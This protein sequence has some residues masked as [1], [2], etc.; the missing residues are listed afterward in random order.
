MLIS[1][2]KLTEAKTGSFTVRVGNAG[3]ISHLGDFVAYRKRR[4]LVIL[5]VLVAGNRSLISVVFK[6]TMIAR[7]EIDRITCA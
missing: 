3:G 2:V 1:Q 4:L 5:V 7:G 6:L